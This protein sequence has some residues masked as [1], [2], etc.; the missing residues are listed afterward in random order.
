MVVRA[1]VDYR[2]NMTTPPDKKVVHPS[3]KIT[4]PNDGAHTDVIGKVSGTFTYRLCNAGTTAAR[5]ILI[6][7]CPRF[8]VNQSDWK[9]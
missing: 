1:K 6:V 5:N 3:V 4:T 2:Q 8:G 7:L 9:D